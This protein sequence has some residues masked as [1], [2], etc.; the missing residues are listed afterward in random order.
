MKIGLALGSGGAKGFAHLAYL[1][2]LDELG[3]KAHI[4]SGSSMG[5]VVGAFYATGMT[6]KEIETMVDEVSFLDIAKVID[7]NAWGDPGLFSGAKLEKFLA[8]R[9]P[10]K[11]FSDLKIPLRI[12]ATDY[13]KKEAHIFSDGP[14]IPAIRASL[15]IPGVFKPY[16]YMGRV[17]I[18]GGVVNPVPIDVI[19][20]N[21]KLVIAIDVSGQ[22][23]TEHSG[24]PHSLDTILTSFQIMQKIILEQKRMPLTKRRIICRPPL[25]GVKILEFHRYKEILAALGPD[26]K[27]FKKELQKRGVIT[28]AGKLRKTWLPWW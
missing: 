26:I 23:E 22:R 11:N 9:L 13:W 14:I 10:A 20:N 7:I 28:A 4:I 25:V 5:A 27:R 18:D 2:L 1:N 16:E 3:I 12:V 15:S 24:I 19:E 17:Y 8:E 21:V 6:A